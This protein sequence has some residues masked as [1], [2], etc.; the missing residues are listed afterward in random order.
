MVVHS[1]RMFTLIHLIGLFINLAANRSNLNHLKPKKGWRNYQSLRGTPLVEGEAVEAVSGKWEVLSNMEIPM[2]LRR[3]Q[4]V[5]LQFWTLS[6][7]SLKLWHGIERRTCHERC[8]SPHEA[9]AWKMN[10][11]ALCIRGQVLMDKDAFQV[12]SQP[13]ATFAE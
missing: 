2:N 8:G 4:E 12:C 7:E 11:A 3:F 6:L 10:G 13:V 9:L 5:M 1:S